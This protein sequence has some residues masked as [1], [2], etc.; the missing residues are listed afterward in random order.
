M[1]AL[2]DLKT[3]LE[4]PVSTPEF[5]YTTYIATTPQKLWQALTDPGFTSRY[6]GVEFGTDWAEGSPMS[7]TEKGAT[8]SHPE[9]VV[10]ESAPYSRLAY[11]WHTFTP[12][13]ARGVGVGEDLRERLA[14]EPRSRVTFE[15]EEVGGT[16]KLTV[17]HDR[18]ADESVLRDMIGQG[19]PHLLASLKTLLETGSALPAVN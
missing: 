18:F 12:E 10:L 17:V 14:A 3:A 6:W 13:W 19:W 5:V 4:A 7:W 11:T 9:Q 15:L 16:V 8:T 1:T 2:A